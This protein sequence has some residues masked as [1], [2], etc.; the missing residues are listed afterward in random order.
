MA[1]DVMPGQMVMRYRAEPAR[2]ASRASS[3]EEATLP[4]RRRT[5]YVQVEALA[6]VSSA[7]LMCWWF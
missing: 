6:V 4:A 2:A 1:Q 7:A 3:I 5:T